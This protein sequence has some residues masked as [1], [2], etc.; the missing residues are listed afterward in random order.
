M[1]DDER[2]DQ[3]RPA[4]EVDGFTA[5]HSQSA[6]LVNSRTEIHDI[7]VGGIGPACLERLR[8]EL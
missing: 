1:A 6:Y 7:R 2:A 8:E 3:Q 4:G 5:W